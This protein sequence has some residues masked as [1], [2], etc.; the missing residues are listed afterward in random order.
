MGLRLEFGSA[1]LAPVTLIS[2]VLDDTIRGHVIELGG[3]L[4]VL[5]NKN[6]SFCR[7]LAIGVPPNTSTVCQALCCVLGMQV[8]FS[9]TSCC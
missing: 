8:Q 6:G 3:S 9:Y 2:A 7:A 4:T 5:P 1:S